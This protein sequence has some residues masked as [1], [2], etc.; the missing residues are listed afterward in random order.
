M[1]RFVTFGDSATL[2]GL[3]CRSWPALRPAP[4][5]PTVKRVSRG[6]VK[7][8]QEGVPRVELRCLRGGPGAASGVSEVVLEQH[9]ISRGLVPGPG[10]VPRVCVPGLGSTPCCTVLSRVHYRTQLVRAHCQHGGLVACSNRNNALGS[11]GPD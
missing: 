3:A 9:L 7:V 1:T 2:G 11:G 8:S 5:R 4:G 6:G 10:S